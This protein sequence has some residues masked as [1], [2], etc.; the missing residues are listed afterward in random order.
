MSVNK[1]REPEKLNIGSAKMERFVILRDEATP[2]G[3]TQSSA[4]FGARGAPRAGVS[5][6]SVEALD[7][8]KKDLRDIARDPKVNAVARIMPIKLIKPLTAAAGSGAG[9][10]WGIGAVGADV[11]SRTGDGVVVAILDTGI[12]SGHPAFAGARIMQQDFTGTGDGDTDGHGTH[13]A[14]TIFGR[15]VGGVRIGVARGVT[16][17]LVGKVL[18]PSGDGSTEMI[19]RAVNWAIDRGAHV[20]SMSL[21]IDF[22]GHVRQLIDERGWPPELATS[23]ALEDYRSN[24]RIFDSLTRMAEARGAAAGEGTVIVAATGNES[25]RDRDPPFEIA[26]SLPAAALDVVSVGALDRS[27]GGLRPADFSNTFPQVSAPGVDIL[28]AGLGGGLLPLSGT[29]M[30]C[31]HVAGVACLWWEE[32]KDAGEVPATAST[33]RTKLLATA[34]TS[35]FDPDVQFVDRGWGIVTAPK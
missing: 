20:V 26:A 30:A 31:P 9:E 11:S 32:L 34:R 22:P 29:S 14:G 28:S 35:V 2:P 16:R 12:E 27:P 13:T 1:L 5:K 8:S 25:K 19:L 17:A 4:V 23:R 18:D 24:V 6:P 33:V 10:A 15:D 3:P 7:L 21:G